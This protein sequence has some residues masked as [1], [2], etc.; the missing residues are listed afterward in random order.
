VSG[1]APS[2]P[3]PSEQRASSYLRTPEAATSIRAQSHSLL[4][5]GFPRDDHMPAKS[6]YFL[7]SARP[8]DLDGVCLAI[9]PSSSAPHDG[10]FVR[11]P[12]S[13]ADGQ[14][15]NRR[16]MYPFNKWIPGGISLRML[17]EKQ[18]GEVLA[19]PGPQGEPAGLPRDTGPLEPDPRL[20]GERETTRPVPSRASA[21]PG[22]QKI[23][24]SRPV[25]G[26]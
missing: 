1:S 18:R 11:L 6:S 9:H 17:S 15:K 20:A 22:S 5:S 14:R 2:P 13:A 7:T 26:G 16:R 10:D 4:L 24:K 19:R 3:R 8:L 25:P 21:L 12:A 23:L